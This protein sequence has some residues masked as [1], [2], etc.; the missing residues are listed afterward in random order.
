MI[1]VVA[2]LSTFVFSIDTLIVTPKSHYSF[3][4]V[5]CPDYS[6]P[7]V[8]EVETISSRILHHFS[9]SSVANSS[10]GVKIDIKNTPTTLLAVYFHIIQYF[11]KLRGNPLVVLQTIINEGLLY[12]SNDTKESRSMC[13]GFHVCWRIFNL[14]Y[15]TPLAAGNNI[16]VR[17]KDVI[18]AVIKINMFINSFI[19]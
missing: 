2:F 16:R 10:Q 4:H 13:T 17:T 3:A 1:G 5:S 6:Q 9:I 12:F 8:L 19:T 18:T 7:M 11:D 14:E 15:V